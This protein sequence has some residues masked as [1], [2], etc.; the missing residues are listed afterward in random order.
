MPIPLPMPIADDVAAISVA[1]RHAFPHS[2]DA[3][4]RLEILP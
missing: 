3:F 2:G 1:L 4:A